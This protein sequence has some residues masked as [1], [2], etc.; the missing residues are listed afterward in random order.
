MF[1]RFVRL[2]ILAA[3]VLGGLYLASTKSVFN[4]SSRSA[5]TPAGPVNAALATQ[6][7]YL[8]ENGNSSC[9]A[10]FKDSIP[11]MSDT[12]RLRGSCCSP[13]SI[14]RYSEQVEGLKQSRAH[15]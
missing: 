10:S 8:S 1:N 2:I 4:F 13:M 5:G 7:D 9:S 14:H 12:E 15:S 6:F 11:S 3:I